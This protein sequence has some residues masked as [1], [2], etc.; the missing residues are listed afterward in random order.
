[1]SHSVRLSK[2]CKLPQL[3]RTLAK[4]EALGDGQAVKFVVP[5]GTFLSL[6]VIAFLCGYGLR[7]KSEGRNVSFYCQRDSGTYLSRMGLFDYL[8]LE[9]QVK[10]NR[11]SEVGRFVPLRLIKS[12]DD[13]MPAVD[14][15]CD[16]I[17]HQFDNAREFLPALEWAVCEIIDNIVI[18]SETTTPGVVCAQYY[19]KRHR[20]DV[21]ICDMGRGIKAGLEKAMPLFS[22]GQAVTEALKRGVTRDPEVGQGNGLAGSL[23]IAQMNQG[24]FG[25]WTGNALYASNGGKE[26]SFTV[27]EHEFPGTGVSLRLDTRRSVDLSDTFIGASSWT[28]VEKESERVATEGGLKVGDECINTGSRPPA[29]RLRRKVLNLLPDMEGPLALD[30]SGVEFCSSSFLDE[31]LGRLVRELGHAEFSQRVRVINLAASLTDMANVVIHQRV[32]TQHG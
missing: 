32:G 20:L 9:E 3:A 14:S 23:E 18:H 15:V 31:L 7:L 26:G 6:G 17:L 10:V 11:R 29:T 2:D 27:M 30:F 25:L 28:Y 12:E 24:T 21:A 22:H 13:V 1:M 4:A 8:E 16:L 19:P 5:E